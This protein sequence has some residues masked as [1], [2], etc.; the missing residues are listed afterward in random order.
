[1]GKLAFVSQGRLYVLDGDHGVLHPVTESG[2]VVGP[3]WS[4]T[5]RWLAFMRDGELWVADADGR[6]PRRPL[7]GEVRT[8]TGLAPAYVIGFAWSSALDVLAVLPSTASTSNGLWLVPGDGSPRKIVT[9]WVGSFAWSP[10]GKRLA[11]NVIHGFPSPRDGLYTISVTD[12]RPVEVAFEFAEPGVSDGIIVAGW[13]P[14]GE[15]VLFW[16]DPQHSASLMADGLSLESVGLSRGVSRT[17]SA[18]MLVHP[19]WLAWATDRRKLMLVEGGSRI[20]WENKRLALCDVQAAT[21]RSLPQPA[22]TVSLDPAWS[23]DSRQ[24][25]FVRAAADFSVRGFPLPGRLK[26]PPFGGE[27][28]AAWNQTHQLWLADADGSNAQ[29]VAE[30]AG[31]LMATWGKDSEHLLVVRD[32][33]LWLLDLGKG[34]QTQVVVPLFATESLPNYYGRV[35]WNALLAW[36]Q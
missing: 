22:G 16:R 25:A 26:Q 17:L 14:T 30:S 4:P 8:P 23:P 13:G 10:D 21:C 6:H 19:A 15:A 34:K 11:Y 33:A 27:S 12:A 31:I 29:Q 2:E 24:L 36:H 28:L 1:M 35:N 3:A 32:N 7:S 18:T 9:E 20:V 5:G